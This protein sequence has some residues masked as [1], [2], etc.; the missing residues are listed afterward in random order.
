MTTS[1]RKPQNILFT[2]GWL[3]DTSVIWKDNVGHS[4]MTELVAR[5]DDKF[6]TP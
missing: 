3:R 4:D 2:R 1:T 5:G 6:W